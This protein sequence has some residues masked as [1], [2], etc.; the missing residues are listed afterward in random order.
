M[1]Y[2][3]FSGVIKNPGW[4]ADND[5]R[6]TRRENTRKIYTKSNEY[7]HKLNNKSFFCVSSIDD[8]CIA[9]AA[10]VDTYEAY[11]E[12]IPEYFKALHL[13]VEVL[14]TKEIIL[15][16]FEMMLNL[17]F[18][19]DFITDDDEIIYKLELPN[20]NSRYLRGFDFG[21]SI[22]EG[23]DYNQIKEMTDKYLLHESFLPEIE[24]IY[25]GPKDLKT[26]GIPVHYFFRISDNNKDRR[27]EIYKALLN[28]LYANKRI[29]NL[30]Y[31]YTDISAD[32][33]FSPR[34]L[35]SLYH[36]NIG[37]AVVIRYTGSETADSQYAS[38]DRETI[39][40]I[41]ELVKK[42]KHHVLTIIC[43]KR[44]ATASL[45]RFKEEMKTLCFVDLNEDLANSESATDY[46]KTLAKKNHLKVNKNLLNKVKD[47]GT[48]YVDDL[49]T[50]FDSWASIEVRKLYPEYNEFTVPDISIKEKQTKG[51]AYQE[52]QDLIGLDELKSKVDQ[53]ISYHRA[54][55]LFKSKGLPVAGN[56]N[57]LHIMLTGNPG[58]CKSTFCGILANLFKSEGILSKGECI[59]A[60]RDSL[61][62]KY[63]G[64]SS[65]MTK[66][67]LKKSKGNLLL[68][69][70][71]YSL[72]MEH[73]NSFGT[74]VINELT[75]L[76]DQEE[77]RKDIVVVFCG[78]KNL[79]EDF[80]KVNPGLNSR[81]GFQIDIPDYTVDE[82]CQIAEYMAKKQSITITEDAMG[83]IRTIC[84]S[85]V[86]CKD[87][88]QG[89]MIRNILEQSRMKQADRLLKMDQDEIT[90]DDCATLTA[91]DIVFPS[92]LHFDEKQLIGFCA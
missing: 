27:K 49:N 31:C 19:N 52:L 35:E 75:S 65:Q 22:L 47:N 56:G 36:S 29:K 87:N 58:A 3:K 25:N 5:S 73:E 62:G 41:S 32:N 60:T 34:A 13:S 72:S 28:A 10:F 12:Q 37:G 83:K 54:Q 91:E 78:Y 17:A 88:G 48:Y 33:D 2:Y 9:G 85:A 67:V 53:I 6:E 59:I 55:Q 61:V 86:K 1:Q 82:L 51:S 89:R 30:R 80:L 71:A 84:E 79:M 77:Y 66:D 43:L 39:R 8:T 21:E 44:S 90:R 15:E 81:I 45:E 4:T 57:N 70:E 18:R 14:E 68:I 76:L 23:M 46:L 92:N 74:E 64:W 38:A 26:P 11:Q 40:K 50:I 69:D 24:R 42:Y 63:V 20:V 16:E 7:N